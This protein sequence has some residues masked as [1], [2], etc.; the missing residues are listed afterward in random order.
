MKRTALLPRGWGGKKASRGN[1]QDRF[2]NPPG[3]LG[4]LLPPFILSDTNNVA[5]VGFI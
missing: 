2:R 4:L 5:A 3:E 1:E